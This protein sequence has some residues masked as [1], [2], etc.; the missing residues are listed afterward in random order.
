MTSEVKKAIQEVAD[1]AEKVYA[2]HEEAA[3]YDAMFDGGEFSEPAHDR[4]AE[5]EIKAIC[6]EYGV[7]YEEVLGEIS[8]RAN[9][10]FN[11]A[12]PECSEPGQDPQASR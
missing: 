9:E 11:A 5:E 7:D 3:Y 10:A 8:R 4:M 1:K 12:W 2:E 6:K